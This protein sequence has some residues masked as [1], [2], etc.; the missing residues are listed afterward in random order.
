[1]GAL[2]VAAAVV[3]VAEL[4]D[5]TQLLAMSLAARHPA[6][7]VLAGV[8]IAY[9]AVN[10]LSV[11]VGGVLGAAL[12]TEVLRIVG[13][14]LFLAFAW[15]AWRDGDGDDGEAPAVE[16]GSVVRST[17]TAM[18]VAELGD[19]TM[20][21]TATLAS[22]GNPAL[23]WIGATIGIL[24]CGGLAVAAGRALGERLPARTTRLASAALFAVFGVLLLA[25]G[26]RSLA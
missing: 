11:L 3:F 24:A 18:F 9:G 21:S 7:P 25:D 20:L 19:K 23:V 16:P 22:Q 26:A 8:G 13:G 14:V 17:A 4:G 2:V 5:K 1:M 10:L 12:P 6:L 15:K